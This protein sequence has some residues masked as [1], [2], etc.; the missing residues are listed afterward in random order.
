MLSI[1]K[2]LFNGRY[3]E[4]LGKTRTAQVKRDA[5]IG[6]AKARRDAGIKQ[7]VADQER[8]KVRFE[9][10]TEIALAKR[11]FDLKKAAYDMEVFFLFL[12]LVSKTS[13]SLLDLYLKNVN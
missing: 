2:L 6:E 5:R 1:H 13:V 10:D 4:A 9:K 11:D 7:A 8:Q 12:K 3:L